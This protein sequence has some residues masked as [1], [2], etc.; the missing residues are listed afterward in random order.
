SGSTM[1]G[2]DAA[3]G[4]INII[5]EPPEGM[6]LRL[7]T[8]LGN[9]GINQQRGSIAGSLGKFS[10]Q[11]TFSRDFSTGFQPDRDYRNLE[12]A[13][14]THLRTALGATNLTLAYMDH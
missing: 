13:S 2:S 4:V 14:S 8:A 3:G 9:Y 12:M 5:T 1:Y 10:E 6:E 7:R 11:L